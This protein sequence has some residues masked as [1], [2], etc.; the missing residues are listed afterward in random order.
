MLH[1]NELPQ[2]SLPLDEVDT[3]FYSYFTHKKT[4]H[5][6][7]VTCP[8]FMHSFFRQIFTFCALGTA[9]GAVVHQ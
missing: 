7:A 8:K 9:L 4:K 1:M 6:K 2:F 5:R 3:I